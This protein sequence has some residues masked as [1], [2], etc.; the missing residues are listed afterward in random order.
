MSK[1]TCQYQF[2][3]YDNN[4]EESNTGNNIATIII[5]DIFDYWYEYQYTVTVYFL[6][7]KS[8]GL[9]YSTR[10]C[11]DLYINKSFFDF[12][13][14]NLHIG[15][16][17]PYSKWWI[18]THTLSFLYKNQHCTW[19][20]LSSVCYNLFY[21]QHTHSLSIYIMGSSLFQVG[22]FFSCSGLICTFFWT[23]QTISLQRL[24]LIS[25]VWNTCIFH[26]LYIGSAFTPI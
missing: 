6:C 18:N 13:Y 5:T 2:L 3:R 14:W 8:V 19:K 4:T 24:I 25:Q 1:N 9:P 12:E 11:F 20:L 22:I 17:R 7:N 10:G 16:V 15:K 26:S 21:A 23:P